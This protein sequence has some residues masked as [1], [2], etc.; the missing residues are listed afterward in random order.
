MGGSRRDIHLNHQ[1]NP[2]KSKV[3]MY[4][5]TLFAGFPDS[6]SGRCVWNVDSGAETHAR[7][8]HERTV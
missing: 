1:L 6:E 8:M 5:C 3:S 2:E 7:Q 4:K